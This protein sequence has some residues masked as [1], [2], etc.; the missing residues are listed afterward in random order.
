MKLSDLIES[1]IKDMFNETEGEINFQRNELANKFNCVPS[2]I[3]YVINSRFTNEQGY[4]VESHRGGGGSIKIT[5]ISMDKPTYL[6]HILSSIGPNISQSTALAFIKNFLDYD[7]V[8]KK[9][10]SM[11]AAAIS[12]KVLLESGE[13]K[14]S[15]RAKILKNMIASIM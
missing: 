3:N 4:V 14:D 12:D 6:M 8:T 10:A 2:Q 1:F 11:M 5:R 7:A 9:E 15:V 13:Y